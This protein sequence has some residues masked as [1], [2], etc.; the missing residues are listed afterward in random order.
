MGLGCGN[1]TA[2][3]SMKLGETV[4][5]LGS[6]GGFDC[7]L[8]ARQTGSRGK[9]IGVDMTPKMSQPSVAKATVLTRSKTVPNSLGAN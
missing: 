3:A 9:V 2:I 4:I 1:L 5:D 6:G 8:A 7:F